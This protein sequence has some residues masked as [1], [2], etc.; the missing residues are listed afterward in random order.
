MPY[1]IGIRGGDGGSEMLEYLQTYYIVREFG[2][3]Y[4]VTNV[5]FAVAVVL[6]L[7]DVRWDMRGVLRPKSRLAAWPF[8]APPI[9]S[10][11]AAA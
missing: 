4:V 11:G 6:L 10:S 2:P 3:G 1:N 8:A 5:F 9:C 7:S